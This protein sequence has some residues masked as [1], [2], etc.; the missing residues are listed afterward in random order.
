[1][2]D[3]HSLINHL[4]IKAELSPTKD[5]LMAMRRRDFKRP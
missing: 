5:Q 1:M 2:I 3:D 4:K